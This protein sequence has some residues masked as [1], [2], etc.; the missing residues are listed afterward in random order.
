MRIIKMNIV[1][2]VTSQVRKL[3]KAICCCG[4][5]PDSEHH[6]L[7]IWKIET[8]RCT[9]CGMPHRQHENQESVMPRR[10][11]HCKYYDC[12]QM[13]YSVCEDP[14]QCRAIGMVCNGYQCL[15]A[16]ES[17][18]PRPDLVCMAIGML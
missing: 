14:Q 6:A 4:T 17:V 12:I 1:N 7:G 2:K 13:G 5:A 11:A 9:L 15:E 3:L 8:D 10:L 18:C 16:G